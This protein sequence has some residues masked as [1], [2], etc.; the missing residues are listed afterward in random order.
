[1]SDFKYLLLYY[2]TGW[3]NDDDFMAVLQ[4]N[5]I[6]NFRIIMLFGTETDGMV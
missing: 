1:M 4:E 3:T 2:I 5:I 6:W